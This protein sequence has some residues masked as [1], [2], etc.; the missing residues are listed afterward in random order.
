VIAKYDGRN[1]G[2]VLF[3]IPT[4]GTSLPPDSYSVWVNPSDKGYG[5]SGFTAFNTVPDGGATAALLGL[6]ILG[7]GMLRRRAQ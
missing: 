1:A 6:G 3:Y 5:I 4:F 7:L 2:Y